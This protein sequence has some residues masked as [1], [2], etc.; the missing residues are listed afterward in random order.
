MNFEEIREQNQF[1]GLIQGLIDNE[2]G[3]CNDFIL[4]ETVIGL[5]ANIQQ[6]SDSDA[7]MTSG[8]GNKGDFKKDITIR[9]DKINWID[10][11]STNPFEVIYLNK[12]EK[13]IVYL[14]QTCFTAI[15]SFESH[16]S[17]Y[18]KSSFYKRHL[19]QF[20]NEKG[21]KYSIVLY[22]NA[23]WEKE[24]GGLLSL[25]PKGKEQVSISPLGGRMVLFRSDEMEHEVNPSFTRKRNSIAGWMKD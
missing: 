10:G 4:P 15:K 6:L 11:Q 2:Y 7:M 16:Y 23:N 1:E 17:S 14:N 22:L 13:F 9:G 5:S 20:K 12:I 8:L 18:E 19:D 24:D 21:R 25:Y 3:C